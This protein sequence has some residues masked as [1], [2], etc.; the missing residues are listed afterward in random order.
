M[1]LVVIESQK[2][3]IL[4]VSDGACQISGVMLILVSHLIPS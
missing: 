1:N 3:Q 4:K 2:E